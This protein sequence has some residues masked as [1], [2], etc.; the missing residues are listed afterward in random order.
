MASGLADLCDRTLVQRAAANPCFFSTTMPL[1]GQEEPRLAVL[2]WAALAGRCEL[3]TFAL[4]CEM[5]I[6]NNFPLVSGL[7]KY[8]AVSYSAK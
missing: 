5:Y 8:S 2:E 4:C 6:I 3:Q 7:L 1:L